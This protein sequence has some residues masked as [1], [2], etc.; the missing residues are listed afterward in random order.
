MPRTAH[1]Q[2]TKERA[3]EGGHCL[4]AS[5]FVLRTNR[6]FSG[7]TYSA[8]LP[9]P[10]NCRGKLG[11]RPTV[12]GQEMMWLQL[13]L[14]RRHAYTPRCN[15]GFSTP[16]HLPRKIKQKKST[17]LLILPLS[18]WSERKP[19]NWSWIQINRPSARDH[20]MVRPCSLSLC[21][22]R[23]NELASSTDEGNRH[24]HFELGKVMVL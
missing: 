1:A 16:L 24:N 5:T 23:T 13:I 22:E 14:D 21:T 19:G 6:P 12:P 20:V 18:P 11:R 2:W 17:C 4:P 10:S 7:K 15:R 8:T 9:H 3:A